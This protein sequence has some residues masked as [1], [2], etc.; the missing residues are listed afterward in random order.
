MEEN[1]ENFPPALSSKTG[2]VYFN[3]FPSIMNWKYDESWIT[4]KRIPLEDGKFYSCLITHFE[5]EEGRELFIRKYAEMNEKE[6][7]RIDHLM[8]IFIRNYNRC[9][10]TGVWSPS[11]TSP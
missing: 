9:L 1:K 8:A 2:H 10:V 11:T 5:Y 3:D 7:K 6:R 4:N